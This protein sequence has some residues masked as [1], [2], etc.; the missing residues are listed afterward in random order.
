[1]SS[2]LAR[3]STCFPFCQIAYRS[4]EN[5]QN[6][7]KVDHIARTIFVAKFCLSHFHISFSHKYDAKRICRHR[8][9][10]NTMQFPRPK[11]SSKEY[12]WIC[13]QTRTKILKRKTNKSVFTIRSANHQEKRQQRAVFVTSE[14]RRPAG[15]CDVTLSLHV[16]GG[17]WRTTLGAFKE[18]FILSV[19][20]ESR[21]MPICT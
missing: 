6:I 9:V 13:N 11:M 10:V 1:M 4:N 12:V 7:K 2:P 21:S 16:G 17:Q 19:V 20:F 18:S 15:A 14:R 8:T 5:C 3:V